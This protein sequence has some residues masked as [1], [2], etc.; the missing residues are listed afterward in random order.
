MAS[1]LKYIKDQMKMETTQPTRTKPDSVNQLRIANAVGDIGVIETGLQNN[2]VFTGSSAHSAAPSVSSTASRFS[3]IDGDRKK[4]RLSGAYFRRKTLKTVIKP[5]RAIIEKCEVSVR[6]KHGLLSKRGYWVLGEGGKVRQPI[7]HPM[8]VDL[9]VG[10][11]TAIVGTAESGKSTLL[12]FLAGCMDDGVVCEGAVNLPGSSS[13][14]PEYTHLH[15]FYTPRTY[16]RHYHRLIS[17]RNGGSCSRMDDE[18]VEK[19]L[20]NLQIDKDRRDVAVGDIFHRGLNAGEQRRLEIGLSV[21]NDPDT[22]FCE[23][24]TMGLDSETSLH[25]MEFLKGYC[26]SPPRRVVITLNKPSQFVWNLID[27]VILLSNDHRLVYSGPRFDLESFFAFNKTPTPRR[28]F[29]LEHYLAVVGKFKSEGHA[30]HWEDAFRKWQNEA[31]RDEGDELAD[32]IETCFPAS[33]PDVAI[34][35]TNSVRSG[36]VVWSCP[37]WCCLFSELVVR[38]ILHEFQNRGM[39]I[40][41]SVMYI[42]LSLFLGMLNF[43]LEK[44]TDETAARLCATL[45]FYTLSFFVFMVGS[46]LPFV[47]LDKSIRD[48]EILNGFY[49]PVTHHAAVTLATIPAAML[50]AFAYTLILA[51]LIKLHNP[52]NYFLINALALWCSESLVLLTSICIKNYIIGVICFSGICGLFMPLMGFMLIPSYF[53]SWLRWTYYIPFHTYACRAL[54]FNEFSETDVGMNLLRWYEMENTNIWRDMVILFCYSLVIHLVC[55]VLLVL[56][57]PKMLAQKMKLL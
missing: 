1:F 46:I 11:I 18:A 8:R 52:I 13:Y 49:H 14:L 42:L 12:K 35:F 39:L 33:I 54:M 10:S 38:Y 55:I 15:G 34:S 3:V 27:H 30:N 5:G 9:P 25:I 17:S 16:I 7:L 47:S 43:N 21:L 22:L 53:P 36:A 28:F 37:R 19:L 56:K 48:K 6:S 4:R 20:D 24:P 26:S 45:L 40:L 57:N 23:N 29:P 32:D 44:N 31:D 41:R 50:L 2:S 51:G